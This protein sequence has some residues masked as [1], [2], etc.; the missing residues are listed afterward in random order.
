MDEDII[1]TL[2]KT[3][4]LLSNK[5]RQY[6]NSHEKTIY[7][8]KIMYDNGINI[9][10]YKDLLYIVRILDKLNRIANI[11]DN[12]E[13]LNEWIDIIGYSTL[14]ATKYK[15]ELNKWKTQNNW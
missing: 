9:N 4:K 2:E 15:K 13:K 10:Q 12:K 3:L 14:I 8:L 6:N 1:Y 11:K 7:I 5:N